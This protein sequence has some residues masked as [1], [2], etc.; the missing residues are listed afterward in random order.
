MLIHR[1]FDSLPRFAVPPLRSVP[2]TGCMRGIGPFW[3]GSRDIA[4][5][6]GGESVV[7][8]FDPH[9]RSVVGSAPVMLLN[10]LPEKL[11]LL[12]G[13]GIDHAVVVDFTPEFSRLSTEEF[14]E[15]D[16]VGRL[17]VDTLLVG[18]NHHLGRDKR[19]DFDSLSELG[20]R[21]GFD[22]RMMPRQD[23][24]AH[25]VSS[26]VIRGLVAGGNLRDAARCLGA[27]Y[28]LSGRLAADGTVLGV[29]S[30]KLLP[31]AGEYAVRVGRDFSD[32]GAD[33]RLTIG[34]GPRCF[35]CTA[36]RNASSRETRS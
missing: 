14:V 6:R 7:V 23:V 29:E 31:P 1:N 11:A 18:Y 25:K 26:T 19:G 15:R 12:A 22:V 17:H 16:L 2:T 24:D 35:A 5:E 13:T 9:P 21:S 3:A 34:P 30:G 4:R 36:A 10:T 20:R 8:T 27:P 32:E 28:F 33:A